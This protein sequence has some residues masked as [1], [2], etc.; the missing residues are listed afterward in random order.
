MAAD[1]GHGTT[2]TFSG[3]AAD[4]I[5]INGPSTSRGSVDT[6][7]MATTTAKT[8]IPAAL[9]DPGEVSATVVFETDDDPVDAMTATA[10]T[11]LTITWPN[12]ATWACSAFMTG[13]TPSAEMEEMMTAE[14]TFQCT[15][16][17]SFST[18]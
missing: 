6:T 3:F 5:S 1:S 8:Y 15:G 4:L 9:Y 14:V 18:S 10:A 13:H 16:T 17:W 7:S 11:T 2:L 12:S